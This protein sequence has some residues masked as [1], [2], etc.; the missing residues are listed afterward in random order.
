MSESRVAIFTCKQTT[1]LYHTRLL[2]VFKRYSEASKEV[3]SKVKCDG[4]Y[5]E[6]F[7]QQLY[8]I[9]LLKISMQVHDLVTRMFSWSYSCLNLFLLTLKSH[10]HARGYCRKFHLE[11]TIIIIV[12][13]SSSILFAIEQ[14]TLAKYKQIWHTVDYILNGHWG[15]CNN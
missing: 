12:L 1:P 10:V 9:L 5:Y 4:T 13:S 2:K 6:I 8:V 11:K 15:G 3:I 7:T 14:K